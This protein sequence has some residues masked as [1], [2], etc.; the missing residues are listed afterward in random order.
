MGLCKEKSMLSLFI[1]IQPLAIIVEIM[2]AIAPFAGFNGFVRV[3][4]NFSAGNGFQGALGVITSIVYLVV[5]IL[6]GN[7]QL[8][9][10]DT[11]TF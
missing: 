11:Y 1:Y 9:I 2:V 10:Q 3:S 8:L 7:S 5:A 4:Q 6:S